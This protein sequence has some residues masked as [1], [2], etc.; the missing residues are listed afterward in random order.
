MKDDKDTLRIELTVRNVND[1]GEKILKH[2]REKIK[3]AREEK[4]YSTRSLSQ[5]VA[6]STS[7]ISKVEQGKLEPGILELIAL[8]VI[9]QK[10]LKYFVPTYFRE[11]EKELSGEEWEMIQQFRRIKNRETRQITIRTIG[12]LAE[13]K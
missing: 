2:I 1:E 8:T 9:L 13:I 11:R 4:D 6:R 3:E 12:Q 5:M 7:F 10:P